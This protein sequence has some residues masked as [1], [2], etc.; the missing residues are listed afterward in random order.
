[1]KRPWSVVVGLVL[2]TTGCMPAPYWA[3][4]LGKEQLP[5]QG[6]E[7]TVS[8]E[9]MRFNLDRS[10]KVADELKSEGVV[11]FLVRDGMTLQSIK[12]FRRPLA[13]PLSATK[14][15]LSK[16]MLPQEMAELIFDQVRSNPQVGMQRLVD[17]APATLSELSGF[18]LQYTFKPK[19]GPTRQVVTY[20]AVQGEWLVGIIYS[21]P[22]RHYFEIG[23]AEFE[24]MKQS[25]RFVQGGVG[26]SSTS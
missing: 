8:P 14:K 9:W 2:L 13:N 26:P 24:T 11:M 10:S 6:V 23:L 12:V 19:D 22:T 25:L 17:N 18:R 7:M 15:V 1:M 4:P 21:A 5:S 3:K 16:D 20:G